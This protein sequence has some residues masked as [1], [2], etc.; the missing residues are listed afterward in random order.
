MTTRNQLQ[1]A[2]PMPSKQLHNEVLAGGC[3]TAKH[4]GPEG[5]K[6]RV[7]SNIAFWTDKKPAPK[8]SSHAFKAAPQR[9]PSARLRK[10]QNTMALKDGSGTQQAG[11]NA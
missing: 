1:S 4:H 8:R 7:E 2:A 11:S 6:R 5:R 9:S 10:Q 3:E